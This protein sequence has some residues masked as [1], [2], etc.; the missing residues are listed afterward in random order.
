MAQGFVGSVA[1]IVEAAKRYSSNPEVI[2]R[3]RAKA[4]KQMANV[5]RKEFGKKVTASEKYQ[6]ARAEGRVGGCGHKE[7]KLS[8]ETKEKIRTSLVKYYEEKGD[9]NKCYVEKHREAMA[10]AKGKRVD[11][12]DKDGNFIETHISI[13]EAA[14]KANLSKGA[15]Q[16]VLS[17]KNKTAGGFVWKYH[18]EPELEVAKIENEIIYNS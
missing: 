10:K 4:I 15:I 9:G 18:T 2:E 14:R 3:C 16:F 6:K 12:Y 1:R 5:D 11:Q 13:S 8:A 7:G 17:G